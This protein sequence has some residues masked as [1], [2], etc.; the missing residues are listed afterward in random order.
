MIVLKFKKI[1]GLIISIVIVITL[2]YT[3]SG[4]SEYMQIK[5][6]KNVV[7]SSA[8]QCCAI[9][10]YYPKDIQYLKDNYG[11]IIDEDKYIVVY[12]VIVSL[13]LLMLYITIKAYTICINNQSLNNNSRKESSYL[14]NKI[15]QIGCLNN[16]EVIEEKY[17]DTII[18]KDCKESI[19]YETRIY[20]NEGILFEEYS[21][22]SQAYNCNKGIP[23]AE[24]NIFN[25]TRYDNFIQ[26]ETESGI[27]YISL[28]MEN[29]Y[30]DDK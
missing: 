3:Y 20:M 5:A 8:I 4:D 2:T 30:E 24:T 14:V 25:V 12:N 27:T 18:L 6:I 22:H 13:I 26:I 11:L 15:Q 16:I 9:E 21:C 29:S 7:K 10:G 1:L 23:I 17:G 19:V 28:R